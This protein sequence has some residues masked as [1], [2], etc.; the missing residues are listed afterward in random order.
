MDK[1]KY[2]TNKIIIEDDDFGS[3]ENSKNQ[4]VKSQSLK[5][6]EIKSDKDIQDE[7][8]ERVWK[9]DS[10]NSPSEHYSS[11]SDFSIHQESSTN[12]NEL[13]E[14]EQF[15][16]LHKKINNKDDR[17]FESNERICRKCKKRGHSK[18]NCPTKT[19]IMCRFCLG[20]HEK[21]ECN[22]QVCFKCGMVGHLVRRCPL[23]KKFERCN[24][25]NRVIL[26]IIY[27]NL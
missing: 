2:K 22:S 13:S 27:I 6:I 26:P 25:C 10:I 8:I 17:Y 3:L 18:Y 16:K 9:E 12:H 24:L 1:S 19:K 5:L 23:K 15:N 11:L 4:S 7:E 20:P 21:R 14:E